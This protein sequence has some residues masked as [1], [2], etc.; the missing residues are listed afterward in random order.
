MIQLAAG[1][2]QT[3]LDVFS[4]Q[5]GQLDKNLR[6]SKPIGQKVEHI[7]D[8]DAHSADARTAA[9]LLG[10]DGYTIHAQNLSAG[11]K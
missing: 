4:L 9:T 5:I 1:I 3:G 2:L 10:V 8:P 6:G 11:Q 7:H